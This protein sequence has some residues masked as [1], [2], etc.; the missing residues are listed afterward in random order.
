MSFLDMQKSHLTARVI[1]DI[2][3]KKEFASVSRDSLKKLA[4]PA[5]HR[6]ILPQT[7]KEYSE[8]IKM[9]ILSEKINYDFSSHQEA[10]EAKRVIVQPKIFKQHKV[11]QDNECFGRP[12]FLDKVVVQ[13]KPLRDFIVRVNKKDLKDIKERIQQTFKGSEEESSY[14]KTLRPTNME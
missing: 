3:S 12:S 6:S 11:L 10:Q 8:G 5:R 2:G 9:M 7:L 13:N 1:D 14:L 4:Q